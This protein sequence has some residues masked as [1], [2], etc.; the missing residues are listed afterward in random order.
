[1]VA[2]A[3]SERRRVQP[4]LL[5][6]HRLFQVLEPLLQRLVVELFRA[7]AEPVALQAGDQQ[8]QPLDLGQRRAQDQLQRRRIVGQG[9][10]A[11]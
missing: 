7:P 10:R 1:M 3:G 11:R 4:G 8:L 5:F 2:S 6:G 9:R